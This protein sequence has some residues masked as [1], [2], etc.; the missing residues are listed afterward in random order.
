[1]AASAEHEVDY[2]QE[3]T[4]FMMA[5]DT[6]KRDHNRPFPTWCE[7]LRVLVKLGYRKS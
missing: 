3:E 7:V 1:M 5:M 2:S 6:Y 4:D